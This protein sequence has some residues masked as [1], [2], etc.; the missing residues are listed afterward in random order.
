MLLREDGRWEVVCGDWE[1]N[2]F[3]P[4][5]AR[6]HED[7]MVVMDAVVEDVRAG[8]TKS[9]GILVPIEA[10]EAI[11]RFEKAGI[12]RIKADAYIDGLQAQ[13]QDGGPRP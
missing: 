12:E 11:A 1:R 5:F 8:R 10:I 9:V 4:H 6:V 7:P 3:Y 2:H 13:T